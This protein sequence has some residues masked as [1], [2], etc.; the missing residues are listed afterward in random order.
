V[1]N[2][3][4]Q[5][6][7]IGFLSEPHSYG[8]GV[9]SVERY[10]THGAIVFVAG[11]RAYKLKRAVKFPYMDYS[12]VDLRRQMCEQ[13]LAVN[14]RMAPD[15][16]LEAC[17][18]VRDGGKL[19]FGTKTE[20]GVID[21]VVVMRRF[22]QSALLEN[23]RRSG[24]LAM[25]LMRLVAETVARFHAKAEVKHDFGGEAGIRAVIEGNAAI[26][27]AKLGHPFALERVAQYESA[28]LRALSRT[29]DLLDARRQSGHVRRCHGDLH[30][31]NICVLDERPV[32][33]DAIEFNDQFACIDVLYDLA[34]LLMDLDQ[35]GLRESANTVLNRY[36]ELSREHTG[37][38]AMSLFLSCRAAVRSH[39]TA[40]AAESRDE[41]VRGSLMHDAVALLDRAIDYLADPKPRL[42]AI[43]GVSGSG[44]STLAYALAPLLGASPGAVVIR[45]D[46]LR[47]QLMGVEETAR[48][49]DT[50]YT[51]AI[52]KRVY[53]RVAEVTS[54]TLASG[55]SAIA[56][57]VYGAEGERQEIAG[58]A[59]HQ[60]AKFDGLWLEGPVELFEQRI[61]ARRCD[62]SDAT[63]RVLRAQLDV[64]AVPQTWSPVNASAS[65]NE[66]LVQARRILG[67]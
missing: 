49:P 22:E 1:E 33:F 47:K 15:L 57:A 48:L 16:Y 58:V 65:T 42:V 2:G 36:L 64:V 40:A 13:E 62:A 5:I 26:L 23:V 45:S 28:A 12:T 53:E 39:T 6:D 4:E 44:K 38:A 29:T 43:G 7:V 51:Q 18:I 67:C 60:E 24:D 27:K 59:R 41:V 55:Y 46:V 14:R 3:T 8:R 66:S 35:H 37:L 17:P 63:P 52:S 50:A 30:L 31:N 19:R 20:R 54:Y 9:H 25:P 56:D 34:F 61:M 11:Q 10:E 32:L 21:W